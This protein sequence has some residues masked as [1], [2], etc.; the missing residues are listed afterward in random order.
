M[1]II[2]NHV[3]RMDEGLNIMSRTIN[4]LLA[5]DHPIVRRGIKALL[6]IQ[7]G[8]RIVAEAETGLEAIEMAK[9]CR[10]DIA[11][12]DIRMP[13]ISGIEACRQIRDSVVGCRVIMLT[14]YAEDELLFAAIEAGASGYILKHT[15]GYELVQAIE[16]VSRGDGVLDSS[17]TMSVI[18]LIRKAAEAAHTAEFVALSS[19]EMLVLALVSKGKTNRAIASHLC[20]GEGTIR[21]YVSNILAKLR[22]R[23]SVV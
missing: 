19:Q 12:L 21:N 22:D 23:K 6:E 15:L 3:R 20:L 8:F 13:S 10:P 11:V 18:K 14:A 1:E 2:A 9:S 17:M 7:N 16:R 4:I 5:D